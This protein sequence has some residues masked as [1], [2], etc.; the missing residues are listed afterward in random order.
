[1]A[2]EENVQVIR[3]LFDAFTRRDVDATL[4]LMA[5]EIVFFA[6]TATLAHEGTSYR[7]HEGIRSY[8][9][10]IDRL[11]EDLQVMPD[12]YRA[13]GDK[14]LVLGQIHARG[15]VG[16]LAD[17]PAGW[18]WELADGKV[19]HGHV[20]TKLEDAFRDAGIEPAR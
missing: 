15:A 9:A 8:F 11:W 18:L 14:V 13:E 12:E 6:P 4:E 2:G 1:M 10:D 17:S 3:R 16:Y 7:G 19:T 5:P 20:Y